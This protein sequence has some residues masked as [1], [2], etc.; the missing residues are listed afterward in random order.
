M[1]SLFGTPGDTFEA[2]GRSE[3]YAYFNAREWTE[4]DAEQARRDKKSLNILTAAT[5][6]EG[7]VYDYPDE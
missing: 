2:N 5:R 6:I 4:E 3:D 7:T 1:D